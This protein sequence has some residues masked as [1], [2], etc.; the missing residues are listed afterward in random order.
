MKKSLRQSCYISIEN[1]DNIG[2]QLFNIAYLIHILNKSNKKDIKRKIVFRKGNNIYSNSLFKGLFT[3]LEDDKYNKISF[4][5]KSINDLDIDDICNTTENIEIYDSNS[6]NITKSFKYINESVKDKIIKLVYSNEDLMYSAYYKYRDILEF[7]GNN[8]KDDDIAVLHILKDANKD[9]D[10]Y[11]NA[12][13]IMEVE[14]IKNIAVVTDDI[15]W[16]RLILTDINDSSTYTFYYVNYGETNDYEI[17]FILISMFKNIIVS[18]N[19]DDM[20]SLW[21]SYISHYDIKKVITPDKNII[22]KYIT[23]IL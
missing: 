21:A 14:R 2:C 19:K 15:E 22:H 5:R 18:N 17:N 11:F 12:L 1:N 8:T 16:A 9:Y 20:D 10:Y 23:D 4:E 7:F 13:S 3:V 6:S